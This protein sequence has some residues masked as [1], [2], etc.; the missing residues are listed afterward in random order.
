M[1]K[2]IL[3]MLML[4]TFGQLTAQDYWFQRDTINGSPKSAM[5]A[6]SFSQIGLII[7][8]LDEFGFKRKMY[9]Y[10]PFQNDW[11]EE[12]S[13]GGNTGDGL[14]RASACAFALT[15][16]NIQKAYVCLGQT[17]TV[18]YMK[19][20]WEFNPQTETWSQKANFAGSA[21]RQAVCFT[22][23]NQAF[24]GTGED[25][26]GLKKDV[27]K[28]DPIMNAWTQVAD[29]A[30]TA[31]RDAVAFELNGMGFIATGDDGVLKNDLWMYDF[32][33]DS[34]IDKAP[35]PGTP[36]AGAV[37]WG[38]DHV[39]YLGMGEDLL[40]DFK[41]DLYEYN[42]YLNSWIQRASLPAPGRKNAFAFYIDGISYVGGGYHG[43]FL[44]DFWAYAGTADVMEK[45]KVEIGLFP[46]PV[47]NE[48]KVKSEQILHHVRVYAMD[49]NQ[50]MEQMIESNECTIDV[51]HWRNGAYVLSCE[52]NGEVIQKTFVKCD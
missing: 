39:A 10:S 41:N 36:R 6:V 8:G 38:A 15:H 51:S 28:Y 33:S 11:D 26:A 42:Y 40:G 48:L 24:V 47:Q 46:N 12:V 4:C 7:G 50:L 23:N 34:W 31:R 37:A 35:F 21:R 27:Y 52:M 29:F 3:S 5:C 17:Q 32:Q 9:S 30:G 2:M 13:L 20:L 22:A 44:E 43:V 1:K 45:N 19:D 49:G 25:A 14:E 18:A 16:E